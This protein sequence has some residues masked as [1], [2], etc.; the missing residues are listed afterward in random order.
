[1]SEA[2]TPLGTMLAAVRVAGDAAHYTITDDWLQ[3]RTTYGGLSAALCLAGVLNAH[4]D[5]PPLRS[6]Q[7]A[8][9]GPAA[10]DVHVR[11]RILRRGKSVAFVEADLF[12]GENLATRA[13]FAFG[14]TRESTLELSRFPMPDVPPPDA[15]EP[16]WNRGSRISFQQHFDS[17][18]ALGGRPV[19][20]AGDGDIAY[21]FRFRDAGDVPAA[22]ALLAIADGPPPAVMPMFSAPYPISSVTW[23]VDVLADDAT[24]VGWHLVRSTAEGAGRGYSPQT[25]GVWDESG[26]PLLAGRQMVAVFG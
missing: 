18:V 23:Q 8:F 17:R 16:L 6:A 14:A 25:M 4:D 21:W 5:L 26:R 20:G 13:L 15:C 1:M 11:P 10:G 2:V 19:S 12:H 22:V 9:I 7:V 24:A 3:G